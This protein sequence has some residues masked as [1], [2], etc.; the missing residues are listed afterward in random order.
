MT[1]I[2]SHSRLIPPKQ[3]P[4]LWISDFDGTLKPFEAPVAHADVEA[5]KTL[6]RLGCVRVV[7]TGRSIAT[8]MKDWDPAFE[9][10]Y[11][12]SSS[13]LATSRFGPEGP[14]ELLTT[15][16]FT[17]SQARLAIGIA[18]SLGLGFFL[19]LPPPKTHRFFYFRP[20]GLVPSCF[21]ARIQYSEGNAAPWDGSLESPLAQTLVMGEPSVM[22]EA[23]RRFHAEAPALSTVV[24]S[25]PYGDGALWLEIYP[26]EVS[27]GKAAASLAAS[28]GLGAWEAVALGNDF[29][30]DD[31]L[32]WAGRAFVSSEAPESLKALY[33][34]VPPAGRGPLAYVA[35]KLVP[36][37]QDR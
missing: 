28:L 5:L 24:S 34:N 2:N 8:F 9:I 20:D 12:I 3:R 13:G 32:Q 17:D 37:F 23:E 15:R 22:R 36:G 33:P 30:D 27:K 29:N 10:D 11:L 6:G 21:D 26:P 14:Q 4:R 1:H 16:E 7:A 18:R 31:L 35:G 19:A 25:S